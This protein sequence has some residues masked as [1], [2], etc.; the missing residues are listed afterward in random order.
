MLEEF[1]G[2]VFIGRVFSGQLQGNGQHVEAV[3][4]HP[5][6]PIRL[7]D[8]AS[9]GKRRA[10]VEDADII[11]TEKAALKNVSSLGVF[12]IHPPGEVQQKFLK[13]SL[14]KSAVALAAALL[15]DL[16]DA[17]CRPRVDWRVDVAEG[18]FV[19]RQLAVGVHVPLTRHEHELFLG[20]V[21]IDERERNAVKREIPGRV[22][23]IF[24][25]VGHGDDVGVVEMAPL[26]VAPVEPFARRF[27]S[28]RIAFDPAI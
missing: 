12:A 22:P 2:H 11:Q 19:G 6:R 14:E 1:A 26:M 4:P 23:R 7:F 28:R 20:E 25:L 13:H 27:R 10:A 24:P 3:H 9:R 16:V 8:V 17:P 5:A 15:L 21:G 18:P